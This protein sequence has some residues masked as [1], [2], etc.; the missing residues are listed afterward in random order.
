MV[1]VV[2]TEV[3]REFALLKLPGPVLGRANRTDVA[4]HHRH[5]GRMDDVIALRVAGVIGP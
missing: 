5:D 1:P 2:V 3:Q 4:D